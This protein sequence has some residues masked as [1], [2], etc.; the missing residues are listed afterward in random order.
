MSDQLQ[1]RRCTLGRVDDWASDFLCR[2]EPSIVP[3]AVQ[4]APTH[5][6]SAAEPHGDAAAPQPAQ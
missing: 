5:S 4:Q 6:R 3:V 2:Q 1:A